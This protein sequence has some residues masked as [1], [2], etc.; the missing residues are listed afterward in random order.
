MTLD[1]ALR[2]VL[3]AL[4]L[5][6]GTSWGVGNSLAATPRI[7]AS[8][9]FP[10]SE[11][12]QG[13]TGVGY[14]VFAGTTVDTFSVTIL[15]VL[16]SY[17]PGFD[18]IMARASSPIVD[19]TGIIAGMS[20][21]PVYI[22]GRLIGAVSYTWSFLK[23]P[24]A[25][26]T[27]I[28][29]M[30][31]LLPAE[32]ARHPDVEDTFGRLGAPDG[33]GDAGAAK[34]IATPISL[35]GF[36]SEALRYLEPWLSERGFVAS[37]GGA[38][39]PGE[40]CDSL[41]PGSAVGVQ[42]IR[43]DWSAAAIGTVTYRDK[44]RILAFGHPFLAMGW[45]EL[46][47]TGATI[48]TIMSSQQISNKIGS[49]TNTCGTVIA[50]RSTGIAGVVGPGPS[51]IP[52]SVSIVGSGGRAKQYHFEVAR[53]RYLT[54]ALVSATVVNSISE[55][56]YDAG[57]TT[58]RYDYSLYMNGGARTIR[59]EDVILSTAPVS[60]V[61]ETVGQSLTLLLGDR[62]RPS[63]LDS[64]RVNV[65]V[66][67]GIDEAALIGIRVSPAAVAAGDS[68]DVDLSLR[69]SSKLIETRRVRV[70][71]PPSAPEGD[72]TVRVCDA[73]ETDRWETQRAPE[74]FQPET[75][76]Q[77][78]NLIES[79]RSAD[80]IYVQLYRAAGGAIV[81]GREISQAPSSVLQVLGSSP[82]SGESAT[83]K[84]ATLAEIALPLG[85]VVRGCET[86][87]VTVI[88]GNR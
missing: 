80:R 67:E 65:R 82:K 86:A 27:P 39:E 12:K 84:G 31:S 61:G 4:L 47:L 29:Q 21:S 32:G 66:E 37:P 18:L 16:R 22:N 46:P 72:L 77:L 87:T 57:V 41:R 68:I 54:P 64:T 30:L 78:A 28:D 25:G 76:D 59:H 58:V 24:M 11:L 63:R 88:P 1:R 19:K 52:V 42:L 2:R 17:R 7:P 45:M 6:G 48:H 8:A 38:N 71:I 9:T 83:T 74:L 35:A 34:P 69:R 23:E 13:M 85:H 60:G 3:L 36:T 26:I 15:G 40:P 49:P 51:M 44:D 5:T 55:A 73:A 50:D 14:T 81:G 79:D 70:R 53:S 20:G 62:F 33:A 10:V 43:G 75:F 56:L